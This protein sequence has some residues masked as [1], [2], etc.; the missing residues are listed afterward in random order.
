MVEITQK[1]MYLKSLFSF[2]HIFF[3]LSTLYSFFH[4]KVILNRPKEGVTNILT[5]PYVIFFVQEIVDVSIFKDVLG[6]KVLKL[7]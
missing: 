5:S 4:L 2:I 3:Y 6:F 1:Q 7:G